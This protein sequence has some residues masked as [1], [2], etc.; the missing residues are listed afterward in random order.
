M[1]KLVFATMMCLA[2]MSAH[3]QVLTSE[4]V[5]NVYETVTNQTDCDFAYHAEWTGKDITAM[6]VHQKAKDKKGEVNLKP[7][8]KYAYTYASDGTLKSRVT[9]RWNSRQHDWV[10]AA[11]H[12]YALTDGMYCADYSRYNHKA[13]CFDLPTDRMVYTLEPNDSINY[14]SCYHRDRPTAPFEL[15]SQTA[16]AGMPLFFAGK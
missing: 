9:Y 8:L 14:I 16:V 13:D 2:A 4:T 11:R 10:I 12:D 6:Y 3:A 7:H 5:N 1:K 15:V